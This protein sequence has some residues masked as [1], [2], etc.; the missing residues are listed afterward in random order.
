MGSRTV[1][2]GREIEG[3]EF[4]PYLR[5]VNDHVMALQGRF[6]LTMLAVDGFAFET[7]DTLGVNGLHTRLNT[8]WRNVADHRLAVYSILVR[9]RSDEYPGG[10]FNN[11]FAAGL[12]ARY[13]E[14]MAGHT[15]YRNDQYLALV[16]APGV[17][18]AR[19]A[20]ELLRLLSQASFA[21]IE[22]DADAVK[23]LQ[24]TTSAVA[25]ALA[26]IGVRQL[27]LCEADGVLFSELSGVL[28][29][30][31]GGRLARIPLTMG[32]VRDAILCDRVIIGKE[33]VELRYPGE[34]HYGAMLAVKEYPARTRPGLF[35]ELLSVPFEVTA[36]QSF[37]FIDKASARALMS[38]KQ[39]QMVNVDDK[40]F[41]QIVDLGFALDDLESNRWVLG[42]H[43][44]SVAVFARSVKALGENVSQ[45]RN[46]MANG[47]AVIVR[48]DLGL[49][50][51]WWAQLPG[52]FR[53]RKRSGSITSA[54]FA[55]LAPFHTY[56]MGQQ[57]GNAW[58]AAVAVLKTAAGSPFYFNFHHNDLGNT[59]ICGPSGSGK[60]VVLNFMLAQLLKHAP[61]M[62][63]F[64]KDRGAELFIR[65][66]GGEYFAL[67]NGQ[68]T[69]FA[70]LKA[71]AY[72]VSGR[73]FL[74]KWIA[75]LAGRALTA[76]EDA[77][78]SR[79][80]KTLGDG[81]LEFRTIGHLRVYLDDDGADGL[82]AR[83]AKW[84][85]PGSLGWVFDNASDYVG[86][87]QSFVGFDMT[88]FLANAEVRTPVMMYLF[89]RVEGWIDG[90]RIVIAIDEFWKVLGDE[91]FRDVV[92]NKLKTIRKQNGMM[93]FAT[94]SPADALRSPI[95]HTIIEQC[96]TQ[97][98]FANGRANR[99][100]YVEGMKLTNREFE[101]IERGLTVESRRFLVKQ[102]H[103]SVV[104]ELDLT[105]FDG[106]LAILS[107]RT[108]AIELVETIRREVGNDPADWIGEFHRRRKAA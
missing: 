2:S 43:H 24:D 60:T 1:L 61:R 82:S 93:V 87:G 3:R 38:R 30:V 80:L 36:V 66:A 11:A 7:A 50:A 64:D 101:L 73:T 27:G 55:G 95:A 88:D 92:N 56:P 62:V 68:N 47:G 37:R 90:R 108:S 104:A 17:D 53:Y 8:L 71:A 77:S 100:D 9:R 107:G 29:R 15:L 5:H 89:Q 96:P 76:E 25:A 22:V 78:L 59:F 21:G 33:T 74:A 4:I 32:T 51:A 54:N 23:L 18:V 84:E 34:T 49:E 40:A 31:L 72:D 19:R 81:P 42:E 35:N 97:I 86:E 94:Q 44:M 67:R 106:E 98:F 41:S 45:A 79:A 39:N 83:L 69:G 46:A 20:S 28:H 13:R 85:R 65:A 103:E 57:T 26:Q 91:Q 6:L 75:V 99:A 16:W 10:V 102:G 70:P 14:R 105:G 52:N 58:G 48:E 63:F 12:D